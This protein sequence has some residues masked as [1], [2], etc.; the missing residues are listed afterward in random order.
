MPFAGAGD[1]THAF[2]GLTATHL[3]IRKTM[4]LSLPQMFRMRLSATAGGD[5]ILSES[6][7]DHV[8][9]HSLIS[10]SL[11]SASDVRN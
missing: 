6:G 9:D 8:L 11:I 5:Q 2:S 7:F 1:S 10:S 4:T 3:A